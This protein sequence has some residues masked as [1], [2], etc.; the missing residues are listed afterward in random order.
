VSIALQEKS[1]LRKPINK[2]LLQLMKT[3]EWKE[4]MDRYINESEKHQHAPV[5]IYP[6]KARGTK[7]VE[8]TAKGIISVF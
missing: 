1:P 2:T 3:E 6:T 7:S 8:L 4:M 5:R